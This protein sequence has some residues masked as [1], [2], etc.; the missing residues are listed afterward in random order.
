[1]KKTLKYIAVALLA[2]C[3]ATLSSC[4]D[5]LDKQPS[6]ELTEEKVLADWNLFEEF[7]YD[8]YNF[9][10]HGALRVNDS[11]LDAATD[12][13]QTSYATAGTR[14]TLNIGNYYGGGGYA[15]LIDTWESRYRGIRK[16]NWVLAHINEVPKNPKNSDE[17]HAGYVKNFTAE[18]RFFRAFF[19]WEM[20]LRYGPLPIITTVLSPDQDMIT[21]YTKRPTTKE[22]VV[23][24]ILKELA[25]CEADLLDK[26]NAWTTQR[27]GRLSQP[28][29]R[30]LAARIKLY[31]AS[32]RYAAESGITW[33]DAADAAKS[34][35]DDY[36]SMFG[37]FAQENI[38]ASDNYGNAVLYSTYSG[39][40]NET[41][42]F[43]NDPAIGWGNIA[44]DT[45]VG[46]G[47]RGG[48][49]PSQNLV[50]MYDMADGS[51]PFAQYD[52]T[53]AP[54]YGNGAACPAINAASG[55]NDADMW[56]NRDPRLAATIL[57]QGTPWGTMRENSTIDVRPG[58]A[59]NPTG[60]A[61]ATPT[62]YYMRK[63][64]P[65][66][67]LSSNHG[68]SALRPWTI[69]R[70]AEILMNYAEAMN[71]LNGPC[72]EVYDMLDRVRTRAGIAGSVKDRADLAS[73]DAMRNF[74]HKERT[75]EFA[76]EE[77]RS[78]DVRRWN[79]AVEALARPIYG[80][81]VAMDGSVSRKVAQQ[82]VFDAKMYLYPIPETEVWKTGIE[83]N[84]GW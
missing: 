2:G 38:S 41:I 84:P 68:G 72:Q 58:M 57:Y 52:A 77:H 37:L 51:S 62:G 24:F 26:D 59:D 49:C 47:G 14:T 64:I 32:P 73:K 61:N 43:R 29:A 56:S 17:V 11:W 40:N 22:Y 70:Y 69:I 74:I 39:S 7:H 82:R 13:A 16:A 79:V 48:N 19:Y 3:G 36:G 9:L 31:M 4:S 71:E 30:A 60:N 5:F 1:M 55:Y 34:F 42:L 63:Y 15:E 66:T 20:F 12:L 8:T 65:A 54:V 25:E 46:E 53:G 75:V 45:P 44:A 27:A 18:A 81:N 23:D 83:N 6:N 21:P 10:R 76:F 35:M 67:I 50:D 78:W 28:A 33:Q 80:I